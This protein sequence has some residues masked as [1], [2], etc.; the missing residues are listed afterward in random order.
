MSAG[1]WGGVGGAKY[2]F[3]GPKGPPSSGWE[4][5]VLMAVALQKSVKVSTFKPTSTTK[6]TTDKLL[7]DHRKATDRHQ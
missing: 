4:V 5:A 7:I 3:S 2:Y 6:K 1:N